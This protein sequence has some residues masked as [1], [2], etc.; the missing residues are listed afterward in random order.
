[1]NSGL[2]SMHKSDS[3]YEQA[4]WSAKVEHESKMQSGE[5]IIKAWTSEETQAYIKKRGY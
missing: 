4:M 2:I 5:C 1:M 3:I